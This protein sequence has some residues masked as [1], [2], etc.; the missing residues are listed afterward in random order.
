MTD[1]A[2]S[3]TGVSDGLKVAEE[4]NGAGSVTSPIQMKTLLEAGVHFGHQTRRWDPKMKPF[5]FTERNGIHIID[6]QQ[7]VRRLE[8]AM[9]FARDLAA[10]GGTILFIGT[11]KQAQE[12]IEEEAK[13]CGMPYINRRWMGGTLTNFQTILGRIRRLEDLELRHEQGEFDRLPKKEATKLADE[14][15]RLERLL[16]GMRKQYRTPQAVFIVDPHREHI[17][18]AEA[19]RS[20]IT[21]VSM[22]DTNCNPELIDYPIPANDDA[23]R[24]IRLLSG[25]IADAVIEGAQQRDAQAPDRDEDLAVAGADEYEGKPISGMVFTP[26]DFAPGE[27]A[28]VEPERPRAERARASSTAAD[29]ELADAAAVAAEAPAMAVESKVAADAAVTAEDT[30]VTAE[31]PSTVKDQPPPHEASAP[32]PVED[33]GGTAVDLAADPEPLTSSAS[34]EEL[35]PGVDQPKPG[36]AARKPRAAS[37]KG[38]GSD[39]EESAASS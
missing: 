34:K 21:I 38:E 3:A 7:T 31:V 13:R 9:N 8:E 20:E 14:R 28:E 29:A 22:V 39:V 17:A 33:A 35:E 15:E 19:R 6:L 16:G 36:R 26:D 30:A 11:K 18:V 10:G 12:T 24:A 5:I 27:S 37:A 4:T 32:M 2:V 1:Q 25:K 23:I